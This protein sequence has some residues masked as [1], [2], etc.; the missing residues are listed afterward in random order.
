[1]RAIVIRRRRIDLVSVRSPAREEEVV[2]R[3]PK[4]AITDGRRLLARP[5]RKWSSLCYILLVFVNKHW[6]FVM[7]RICAK[8]RAA[9]RR[10]E[11]ENSRMTLLLFQRRITY[12]IE[13]SSVFIGNMYNSQWVK[14]PNEWENEFADRDSQRSKRNDRR[15]ILVDP[16]LSNGQCQ[17]S[18]SLSLS[19][20]QRGLTQMPCTRP[21]FLKQSRSNR[22]LFA[23]VNQRQEQC[24][25]FFSLHMV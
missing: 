18:L 11:T 7:I 8:S 2:D 4:K 13:K 5:M 9:L 23:C 3:K 1:M 22:H 24:N 15:D 17:S 21:C 14:W 25:F 10:N 20:W 19:L 16:K 6:A 12:P